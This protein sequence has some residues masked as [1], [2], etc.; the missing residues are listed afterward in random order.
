MGEVYFCSEL[1][2]QSFM[3]RELFSIVRGN[4]ANKA[5]VGPKQVDGC[6]SNVLGALAINSSGYGKQGA[7]L[8]D[9]YKNTTVALANDC[10]DL[11][12]A[13]SA[14]TINDAWAFINTDSI[15]DLPTA[16]FAV[17]PLFVRFALPTQVGVEI[18]TGTLIGPNM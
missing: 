4:R 1:F 9:R 18:S 5:L 15:L 2:S 7:P 12:V 16:G 17:A 14:F 6:L 13:N 10:V 8:N 3:V 11:P